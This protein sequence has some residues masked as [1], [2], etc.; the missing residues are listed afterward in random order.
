VTAAVSLDREVT[1]RF[2]F[3]VMATDS[4]APS[5][6]GTAL[7]VVT[8]QDVN[9]NRPLFTGGQDGGYVFEV[10]ENQPSGTVVAQVAAL[11]ADSGA[12]GEV[13]YGIEAGTSSHL[14]D[15]DPVSGTISSR[16]VTISTHT[17]RPAAI[18]FSYLV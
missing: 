18:L 9:D 15:I 5:L 17:V 4:G 2:S 14:F 1:S 13:L 12:N 10:V 6:S 11:D 16:Q 3:Y 8:V 7:V